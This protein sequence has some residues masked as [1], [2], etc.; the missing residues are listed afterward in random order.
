MKIDRNGKAR[1]L[2]LEDI[3]LLFNEGLQTKRD[4]ALFGVCLYTACR[5]NEACT[6]G[7]TDAYETRK[8]IRQE[9]TFR[10]ANTK[11]KLNTRAVPIIEELRILLLD[12]YP[13]PRGWFVF[14]SA[15]GSGHIRPDSASRILREACQRIN[16]RGVSTHSFRRTALTQ[17]SNN[18]VPLRVIQE[19][20]G[21]KSLEQLQRYLE[22]KPEQILGAVSGLSVLSHVKK[23]L[24]LDSSDYNSSTPLK[25]C[26]SSLK[27]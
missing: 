19:I 5:I 8:K 2:E 23:S 18:L 14:P 9:I 27:E 22:V 7:I 16:L 3:Q 13:N 20:S 24:Y 15:R 11:G 26:N 10:K 6:L 4:R 25:G 1:V 17:M 21:H 12:Y